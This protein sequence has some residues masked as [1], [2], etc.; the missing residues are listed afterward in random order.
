MNSVGKEVGEV[1]MRQVS[2]DEYAGIWTASVP[3]G[4]YSVTLIA[5]ASGYIQ[6]LQRCARA[7]DNQLGP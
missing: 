7:K 3:K 4:V 1:K 6:N 5:S 2:G